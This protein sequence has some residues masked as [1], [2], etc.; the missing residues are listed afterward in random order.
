MLPDMIPGLSHFS[1]ECEGEFMCVC[2]RM[3]ENTYLPG[4]NL[5]ET[6]HEHEHEH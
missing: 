5:W 3:N 2:V 6:L 1:P 4:E